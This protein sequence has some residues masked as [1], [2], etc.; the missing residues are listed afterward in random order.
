[1]EKALKHL[2]FIEEYELSTL[3]TAAALLALTVYF[4]YKSMNKLASTEI[5]E[6]DTSELADVKILFDSDDYED[7]LS[8]LFNFAVDLAPELIQ[9]GTISTSSDKLTIYS[10][11]KQAEIGDADSQE[12]LARDAKYFAWKR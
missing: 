9:N 6:V 12:G 7:T 2:R 8:S 3:S 5:R 11:F 1:M 10:L 4:L